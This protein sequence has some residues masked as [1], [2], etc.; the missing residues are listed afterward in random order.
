MTLAGF[1]WKLSLCVLCVVALTS[2][3]SSQFINVSQ[4]PGP[5]RH[6]DIAASP[7]GDL[8]V[9][10]ADYTGG[11]GQILHKKWSAGIWG[12]VFPVSDPAFDA[13]EPSISVDPVGPLVL[14]AWE[15]DHGG[16]LRVWAAVSDGVIWDRFPVAPDVP[17]TQK[18]ADAL[19]RRD[20]SMFVSWYDADSTVSVSQVWGSQWS[21]IVADVCFGREGNRVVEAGDDLAL[22][23][24]ALPVD[25]DCQYKVA[26]WN[27]EF[28]RYPIGETASAGGEMDAVSGGAED[29]YVHFAAH[30]GVLP[31]CPCWH[32]IYTA[33][34]QHLGTWGP[35]EVLSETFS[36]WWFCMQPDLALDEDGNPVAAYTYEELDVEFNTIRMDVVLARRDAD[37]ATWSHEYMGL[38]LD[39]EP[40]DPV[41]DFL[42]RFPAMA[43]SGNLDEVREI[44]LWAPLSDVEMPTTILVPRLHVRPNP[45]SGPI[46]LTVSGDFG[47]PMDVLITDVA[48]RQVRQLRL[49]EG[50]RS[51]LWD[52]CDSHGKPVGSGIYYARLTCGAAA[53][54]TR[55]VR[56]H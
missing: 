11:M 51:L 50:S 24:T 37:R 55:L 7:E 14:I 10:W 30:F 23:C 21:P 19:I 8:H 27:G 36:E 47:T 17:G 16:T 52:G 12:A 9:V 40:E 43:W 3:A 25:V 54:K 46:H 33:W 6:P 26:L 48:G 49:T 1:S 2:A 53:G 13:Q 22:V 32:L 18:D 42:Y 5:S 39:N 4:T 28:W 41:V 34:D 31:P 38:T 35:Q 20:G 45:S 56:I 15:E 29:Q 44:L